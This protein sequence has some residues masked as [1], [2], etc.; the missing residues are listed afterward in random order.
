MLS[1][2]LPHPLSHTHFSLTLS[3]YSNLYNHPTVISEHSFPKQQRQ[4]SPISISKK[5]G[6]PLGVI[7][8]PLTKQKPL[9]QGGQVF[10]CLFHSPSECWCVYNYDSVCV[11]VCVCVP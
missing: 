4:L 8:G 5:T 2:S 1:P 6:V 11:C 3:T 9:K 7:P 10:L